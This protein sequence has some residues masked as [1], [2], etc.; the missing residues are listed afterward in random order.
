[1]FIFINNR[2]KYNSN[3]QPKKNIKY[4]DIVKIKKENDF[5]SLRPN[6]WRIISSYLRLSDQINI[7]IAGKYID[8]YEISQKNCTRLCLLKLTNEILNQPMFL[9]VEKLDISLSVVNDIS[10]LKNVKELSINRCITDEQ[11]NKFDLISLDLTINDNVKCISQPNLTKLNIMRNQYNIDLLKMP[12]ITNL[13]FGTIG[14]NFYDN[15]SIKHL[16][17]KKLFLVGTKITDLNSQTEITKLILNN[18]DIANDGIN[19]L[20]NLKYLDIQFNK[21]NINDVTPFKKLQMI[22]C[23]YFFNKIKYLPKQQLKVIERKDFS[24][25]PII[26]NIIGVTA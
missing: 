8:I 25:D 12:K 16:K 24:S 26:T 23:K 4:N 14:K 22:K 20:V 10:Y 6:I 13:T 9:N 7:I 1:M 17:L 11:I 5:L 2:W 3:K 15:D 18:T 21:E 19:K